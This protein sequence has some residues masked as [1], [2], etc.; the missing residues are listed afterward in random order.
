M[1][2]NSPN[3][4]AELGDLFGFVPRGMLGQ[5]SRFRQGEALVAGGFV[6]APSISS[7]VTGSPMRA[8]IDVPVRCP[9]DAA[10]VT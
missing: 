9:A 5:A 7:S 6:P 2:M 10:T 1:R 8:A 3:D 4:L